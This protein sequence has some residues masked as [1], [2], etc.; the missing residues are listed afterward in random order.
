MKSRTLGVG[1]LALSAVLAACAAPCADKVPCGADGRVPASGCVNLRPFGAASP[2]KIIFDTDMITDYDDMGALATL[3]ALADRGECEILAT[4][5]ST[6]GNASVAAI[7]ICNAFC[8]RPGLPVGAPKSDSAVKGA[9]EGHE[10]YIRLRAKY[11]DWVRHH[12]ADSAPDAVEVY[13][14]VLAAQPDKSVVVCTVGFL[15]NLQWLLASKPD[16]ISPLSGRDLV[17]AKVI[18]WVAMGGFYPWGEEYN[19]K[20]DPVASREVLRDWP[21]PMEYSDGQY[22]KDVYTGRRLAATPRDGNPVY[23]VYSW[24]LE[25]LESITPRSWDQ[26]AGHSSWDQTA[27]LLAVRGVDAYFTPE[28]GTYE[29]TDDKGHD[30]WRYDLK[31]PSFRIIEKTPRTRVAEVIDE[32]M[33]SAGSSRRSGRL[34]VPGFHGVSDDPSTWRKLGGFSAP[35]V[36][37]MTWYALWFGTTEEKALRN[38]RGFMQAF[39]GRLAERPVFWVDWEWF[40]PQLWPDD[41]IEGEDALTPRTKLYPRGL[42][43]VA[44]DLKGMGYVPGLWVSIFCDVKTNAMLSAHGEWLLPPSKEW[45]GPVWVDPTAPGVCESYVPSLFAKY[46]EWGYEAFKWDT[47]PHTITVYERFKGAMKHPSGDVP[48]LVR[49]VVSA[50]RTALGEDTY[51]LSC[52]GETDAA[53]EACPDLFSAARIGADVSK[54]DEFVKEGVDRFLKYAVQL[55]HGERM[56]CD[57]DNLVLREEYSTLAQ[58]RTRVS[59]YSLFGVPLTLGDEIAALDGPR[60]DMLRKVLPSF[61]VRPV[62]VGRRVPGEVFHTQVDFVRR[63]GD[64]SL[65]AFTNFETNRTLKT[66][67]RCGDAKVTDFWTGGRRA[68]PNG[69]VTLEIPPCDTVVLRVD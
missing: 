40:H 47:L 60:I 18:R 42:A 21:T 39:G 28:Y 26:H 23:D 9:P 62:A 38:A 1:L 6:R 64:Y 4:V 37:W 3:H 54:W 36:G 5:S 58:A 68:A 67:F 41:S 15:T 33:E 27:V 2:V 69:A 51:V 25:P 56:W 19:F 57:M 7:E 46:R 32:L 30:E 55:R 31:S 29:M 63:E 48:G 61:N 14:R 12:D 66:V 13:R 34:P 35:P 22:G 8:G 53:V 43:A 20:G 50:G 45:C 10:K 49:K 44:S 59:L 65:H 16:S 52:S 17:K 11:A 24:T